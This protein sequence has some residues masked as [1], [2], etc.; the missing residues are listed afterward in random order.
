MAASLDHR[1]GHGLEP[2][3]PELSFR[4]ADRSAEKKPA[5]PMSGLGD[6][7]QTIE[8]KIQRYKL[9]NAA[10]G[11]RQAGL[12]DTGDPKAATTLAGGLAARR[13]ATSSLSVT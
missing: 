10:F 7:L 1:G 9:E 11:Q 12:A 4:K 5:S 2:P 8:A 13:L 6:Q 3:H